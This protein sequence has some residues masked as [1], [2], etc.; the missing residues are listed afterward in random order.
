MRTISFAF[1]LTIH[2]TI[3]AS[4]VYGMVSHRD[5]KKGIEQALRIGITR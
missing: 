3:A 1:W 2:L 5:V 4:L